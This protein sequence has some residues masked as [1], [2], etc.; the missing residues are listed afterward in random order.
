MYQHVPTCS[1]L[2]LPGQAPPPCFAVDAGFVRRHDVVGV[3]FIGASSTWHQH[4]MKQRDVRPCSK[5]FR[6]RP[7]QD[8]LSVMAIRVVIVQ[9]NDVGTAVVVVVVVVVVVPF[10][11]F[12]SVLSFFLCRQLFLWGGR[13]AVGIGRIVWIVVVVGW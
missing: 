12:V 7:V 9:M 2:H 5:V 6:I 8:I 1:L 10:T 11:M 13:V 3:L 4:R